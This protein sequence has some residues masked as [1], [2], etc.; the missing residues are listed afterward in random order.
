MTWRAL[1]SALY[2]L[3]LMLLCGCGVGATASPPPTTPEPPARPERL[4]VALRFED[5]GVDPATETPHTRVVLALVRES[6]GRTE[7]H[8]VGVIDG[9]C[10]YVTPTADALLAGSCWWA[11]AGANYDVVRRERVLLVR[12]I[13]EDED[14]SEA[15]PIETVLRL[16]LPENAQLQ[17]IAPATLH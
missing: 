15:L 5:A 1:P 10:N 6:D 7:T 2:A 14:Q 13:Y 3:A 4:A 16:E 11:G 12:R 8:E 9:A 17:V